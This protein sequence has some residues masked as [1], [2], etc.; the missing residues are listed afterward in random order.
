MTTETT[1]TKYGLIDIVNLRKEFPTAKG[2]FTAV[3]GIDLRTEP[4]NFSRY[5]AR[6]VVA[7][8]PHSG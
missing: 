5:W 8:P 3:D 1:Q 7:K 6:L 4:A 2:L